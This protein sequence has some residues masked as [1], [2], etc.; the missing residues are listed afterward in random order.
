[1][2]QLQQRLESGLT[3]RYSVARPLGEGGM[4]IVFLARDLRHERTVAVKVLRPEV[5]EEI[6]AER[7]LREIKMAASLTHPHILPVFDSGDANGLL[8]YVMPSMEG[9]SLRHRL[10]AE[11]QL[12]LEDAL[13]ITS[14]VASALDYSHRHQVV[15][16]DIKPENILLHEGAALVAD[17]GIGKA[18]SSGKS[19]THSGIAVGTPTY[20]SPEQASG[21]SAIDG[22][23]DLYSLGCVL[24]EM[25]SGEPP[26]TGPNAQ[27]IIAKRFMSPVPSVKITRDVP[28]AVEATLSRAL[29]RSPADRYRSGAELAD[30]LRMILRTGESKS[31][32]S[33]LETRIAAGPKAIA[34]LPLANMSADPENEYFSDGMTE[35]IINALA[36]VPG[37][38]VASRSSSFAF[39]GNKT[40]DVRQVGE[41]L[42]V[43]SVLEGSVR[44]IGNRIRIAAQLVNVENGYQLWSETYD[45]QLEDVFAVQDEISR[46]IVEAL[47]VRLGGTSAQV[48]AP[49]KN[50]EAYTT[51]LKGRYHFNKF[52]EQSLRKALDLFQHAL[53]QD[54]GFAR[55]YAG[56]ADVWCDLADDWVA[57]DDAYPR[58]KAAAERAL[59]RDPELADAMI[60]IG[61]VLCWHE[62]AFGEGVWQLERAIAVSPNNS[63]AQWVLGT[64]LPLVGRLSD[65]IVAVRRAV[66]LDPLRV[67]YAGWLTR[68]LLYDKDYEAAIAQGQELLE[69][70]E[71]YGR[72]FVWMGSAY[73][74]LGNAE[75][76]LEWFQRGQAL[77]R[78]VRSYDALIVRALAALDRAE[79]AE[80]IMARLEAESRQQ[81]VRSE[82]L[83]MGHAALGNFDRA[84]E[85]LERAYQARSA[86]LIYLHLD[87]GYEP[88]RLDP[89]YAELVARV[90][91]R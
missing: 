40:V 10:D 57:P 75:L 15:H 59:Q 53:L 66:A 39:K 24:Y 90:G 23:S 48:V 37:V 85:S 35:E 20:M 52:S 54:P 91:V 17:F 12:P 1:M 22:R 47:K 77:D 11:G 55:A 60:S 67:E 28:D 34:V 89:R 70:D 21:E 87:P 79:E 36:K 58:A 41:R 30:A 51:Y 29:A 18:L 50:L 62:W 61:K 83:A 8:F 88:L 71:E 13:R 56:I 76:A 44:K 19:L 65:G 78:A 63:E 5:S 42:G 9:H 68:F 72:G 81:Y 49:T 73:L 6:G 69:V 45:R 86:G 74:A 46:S 27:S 43:T 33:P 16:R 25:L 7:F 4:A 82:Y 64:A 14:E 26:F 31:V 32:A 84:F 3:G 38:H 2:N 80:E